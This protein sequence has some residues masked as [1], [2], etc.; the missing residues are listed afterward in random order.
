[1]KESKYV[2]GWHDTYRAPKE[3]DRNGFIFSPDPTRVLMD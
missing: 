1:M 3:A 2:M